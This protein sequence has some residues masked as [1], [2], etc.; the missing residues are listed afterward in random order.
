[1]T[2]QP[3]TPTAPDAGKTKVRMIYLGQETDSK[4]RLVFIWAVTDQKND[5]SRLDMKKAKRWVFSRIKLQFLYIGNIYIFDAR[6]GP[7]DSA[8]VT[9]KNP[10]KIADVEQW[11]NQADLSEWSL[12]QRTARVAKQ[13][14]TKLAKSNDDWRVGLAPYKRQYQYATAPE[15]A[16]LL[17]SIILEITGH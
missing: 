8:S 4:N 12:N 11:K 1:M 6:L 14:E 16:A 17:A 9:F 5:G 3:A 2:D 15:R 13:A 10:A 7:D